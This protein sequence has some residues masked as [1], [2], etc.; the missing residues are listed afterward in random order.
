MMTIAV[1]PEI[2][3]IGVVW[4]QGPKTFKE[5]GAVKTAAD[6]RVALEVPNIVK[7]FTQYVK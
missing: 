3:Q 7:L 4:R 5:Q 1:P 2:A 6:L